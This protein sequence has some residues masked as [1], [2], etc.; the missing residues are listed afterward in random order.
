MVGQS[1]LAA[2]NPRLLAGPLMRNAL[3]VRRFT[4]PAGDLAQSGS[5]EQCESSEMF[6]GHGS[7]VNHGLSA[8]QAHHARLPVVAERSWPFRRGFFIESIRARD[9]CCKGRATR[10]VQDHERA[11]EVG[12]RLW[13]K[14]VNG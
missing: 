8:R 9:V 12:R 14:F 3:G 5:I 11:R 7:L 4:A 1:A 10:F 13:R 6:G 2:R